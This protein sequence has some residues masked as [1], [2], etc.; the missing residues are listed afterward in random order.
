M[1]N[2][3]DY[4]EGEGHGEGDGHDDDDDDD[5]HYVGG[6][7]DGDD[8]HDCDGDG[9]GGD[10]DSS[11]G[12]NML[13]YAFRLK[14]KGIC[15][16]MLGISEVQVQEAAKAKAFQRRTTTRPRVLIS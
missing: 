4:G 10:D 6:N 11:N 12:N 7:C 16:S 15:S 5:H 9:D 8:D 14:I 2:G 1:V 3:D 13:N